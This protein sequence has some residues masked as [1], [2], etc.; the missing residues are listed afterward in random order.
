M[1]PQYPK[2]NKPIVYPF[3][4]I[5]YSRKVLVG[6]L[7]FFVMLLGE[8]GLSAEVVSGFNN[9]A[10]AIIISWTAKDMATNLR[11]GK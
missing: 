5:L 10:L 2:E 6:A 1:P 8:L 9:F 4:R 11:N 7:A 3:M